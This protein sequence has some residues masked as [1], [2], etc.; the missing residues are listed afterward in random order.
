MKMLSGILFTIFLNAPVHSLIQAF[1]INVVV[2]LFLLMELDIAT[3][4]TFTSI[5][6]VWN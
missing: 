6:K 4:P 3:F 1:A 2:F 5:N